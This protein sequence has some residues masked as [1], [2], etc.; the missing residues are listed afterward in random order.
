MIVKLKS[1]KYPNMIFLCD[2]VNPDDPKPHPQDVFIA[3][4]Y[5]VVDRDIIVEAFINAYETLRKNGSLEL[6]QMLIYDEMPH[7]NDDEPHYNEQ[8]DGCF[9][10][11][12]A[13]SC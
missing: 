5:D 2:K 11:I 10:P 7:F 12:W 6:N 1:N 13:C 4:V 9:K 3:K 8:C